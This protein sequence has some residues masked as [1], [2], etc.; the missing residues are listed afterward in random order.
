MFLY[1]HNLIWLSSPKHHKLIQQ[2]GGLVCGDRH[3][4]LVHVCRN[5]AGESLSTDLCHQTTKQTQK[6]QMQPQTSKRTTL[7]Y[8]ALLTPCA[9]SD[10]LACF[11]IPHLLD[12]TAI[13]P[14]NLVELNQISMWRLKKW[15]LTVDNYSRLRDAVIND[16]NAANLGQLVAQ[17]I[18]M[19]GHR[20]L[21]SVRY[22]GRPDLFITFTRN[23]KWPQIKQDLFP[24]QQPKDRHAILARVFRQKMLKTMQLLTK[25]NIFGKTRCNMYTIE[26]QKC[27]LPYAHIL[28]WL[29][30]KIHANLTDS[31]IGVE[32]PDP[33]RDPDLFN[34]AKS[35]MVH[36]PCDAINSQAPYA[37]RKVF[38]GYPKSF[39]SE[40]QTGNDGCQLYWHRKSGNG[41]FKTVL[42]VAGKQTVPVDNR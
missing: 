37:S 11:F 40:T 15:A 7:I 4:Q 22:Y 12:S 33:E 3:G 18:G 17:D 38:K 5:E 9:C 30:E 34:I 2:E 32:L 35:Q 16:G 27:G 29:P 25:H 31:F 41:G 24:N 8:F 1:F 42:I 26:W 20:M 39:L 10:L 14:V 19:R 28:L 23:P 36:G 6:L 21:T 13:L